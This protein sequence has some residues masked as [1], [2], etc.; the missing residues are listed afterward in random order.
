MLALASEGHYLARLSTLLVDQ[1][2]D[3]HDSGRAHTIQ[4]F[5]NCA[6][7]ERAHPR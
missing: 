1:K 6:P 4:R 3:P 2:R 7:T 5:F